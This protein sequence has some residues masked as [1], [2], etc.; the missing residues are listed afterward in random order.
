[1][2]AASFKHTTVPVYHSFDLSPSTVTTRLFRS[3]S[4]VRGTV[5]L[6][7]PC[8][9]MVT[10]RRSID[11]QNLQEPCYSHAAVPKDA[12]TCARDRITNQPHT[13]T[14]HWTSAPGH[15]SHALGAAFYHVRR[16]KLRSIAN[17]RPHQDGHMHVSCMLRV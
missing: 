7:D 15:N 17:H 14:A 11:A 13:L 3:T 8:Q 2:I 12:Y 4:A 1:M 9:G 5:R 16:S 10:R 6:T